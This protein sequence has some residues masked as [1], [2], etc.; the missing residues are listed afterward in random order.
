[1][2]TT[3]LIPALCLAFATLTSCQKE[4][5]ITPFNASN[6]SNN[7]SK[8][9]D[10]FFLKEVIST[11][12]EVVQEFIYND[13]KQITQINLPVQVTQ[14]FNYDSKGKLENVTT[15]DGKNGEVTEQLL[16]S[17][18]DGTSLPFQ[19][20][21]FTNISGT[22][23][24]STTTKFEW[25][26][27]GLKKHETIT[28]E[29][30]Q[31]TTENIFTYNEENLSSVTKSVNGVQVEVKNIKAYDD[32]ENPF[33]KLAVMR[34]MPGFESFKNNVVFL[35]TD[36]NGHI[37]NFTNEITYD[38]YDLPSIIKTSLDNG[39]KVSVRFT[40]EKM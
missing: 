38:P 37:E 14:Y 10:H 7:T 34:L 23:K 17:Y 11:K 24:L 27:E 12:G 16:Y 2:K 13:E 6:Q 30:T 21:A 40:Y 18:Y 31:E 1:M 22:M 3:N 36:S 39:E 29:A 19:M 26:A 25:T 5:N 28:D 4:N 9:S 33:A 15:L 35:Y 8:E 20:E 32:G